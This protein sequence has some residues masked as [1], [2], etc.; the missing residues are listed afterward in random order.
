MKT[1]SFKPQYQHVCSPQ[2][3]LYTTYGASWENLL[4]HQD[5]LS[6]V[7]IFLILMIF[8]FEHKVIL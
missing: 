2:C 7:I 4:T 8:M 1:Y 6:L 5:I 3:S